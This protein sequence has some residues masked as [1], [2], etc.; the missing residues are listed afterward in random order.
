MMS[1][2]GGAGEQGV[3]AADG[4]VS[5]RYTSVRMAAE[6]LGAYGAIA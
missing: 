1:A 3:A 5:Q 2:G 6:Y 4:A